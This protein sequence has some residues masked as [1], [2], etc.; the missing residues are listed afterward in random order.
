MGRVGGRSSV[1]KKRNNLLRDTCLR[2]FENQ[3]FGGLWRLLPCNEVLRPIL[4]EVELESQHHCEWAHRPPPYVNS[5][6][7]IDQV[8]WERKYSQW[9][10]KYEDPQSPP[11]KT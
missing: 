3:R 7:H 9:E 6:G 2:L 4:T 11:Q 10:R 5:G 1:S 8:Q